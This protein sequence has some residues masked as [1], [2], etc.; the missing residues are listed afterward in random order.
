M[1]AG[2]PLAKPAS[3]RVLGP[4]DRPADVANPHGGTV[5]IGDDEVVP[6][7]GRQL[8]V[9]GVEGEGRG[10]PSRSSLSG[11]LAVASASTVRRPSSE[12]PSDATLAGSSWMRTAGFC[13]PPTLT[14]ATPEIWLICCTSTFSA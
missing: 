3:L 1:I 2:W 7:L 11:E 5:S 4:V 14:C 6:R 13:C 12:S 10:S 9:V 8:L